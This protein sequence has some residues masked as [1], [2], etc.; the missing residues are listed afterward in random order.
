MFAYLNL[1]QRE[2]EPSQF[3]WPQEQ[4][5]EHNRYQDSQIHFHARALLLSF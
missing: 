5:P 4:L 3:Y 2:S 1:S